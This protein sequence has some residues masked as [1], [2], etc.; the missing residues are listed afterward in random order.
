MVYTY[1]LYNC[2]RGLPTSP[3]GCRGLVQSPAP[4]SEVLGNEQR[5]AF[6]IVQVFVTL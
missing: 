3:R 5:S 6:W 1:I 4:F 2:I